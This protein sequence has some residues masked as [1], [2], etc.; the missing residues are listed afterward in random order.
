MAKSKVVDHK[1][2]RLLM[3]TK[4][5]GMD[6]LVKYLQESDFFEAPASTKFHGAYRGG[7]VEHVLGV[8][9]ILNACPFLDKL[10][11][12]AVVGQRPLEI[13]KSALII[14]PLLHDLCKVG[15]YV[16]TKEGAKY[17][18][19]ATQG[20]PKGHAKVSID[21]CREYIQLT[22]LETF[23]IR[24]HMGPY[25]LNEF[26]GEGDWQTGDYPIGPAKDLINDLFP[27]PEFAARGD[28]SNDA[29]ISREESKNLRYGESLMNV[30]Y[31]N[32]L[33]KL[34]YF[35]DE[36]S[37]MKCKYDAV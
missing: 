37:T 3:S 20:R 36:M 15:A 19:R 13:T 4:R 34:M 35:A 26:Y 31:H 10:D 29:N 2:I 8:Y 7:L 16:T 12:E 32:P 11:Q 14:P 24:Y 21:I 23:M 18:Y 22:Q 27:G 25:A 1:I 5:E 6:N 28:H 33:V 9:D 30:W 17:P